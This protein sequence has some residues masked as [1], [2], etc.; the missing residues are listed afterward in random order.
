MRVRSA[1]LAK[2]KQPGRLTVNVGDT[3]TFLEAATN[4]MWSHVKMDDDGRLGVV[5]ASKLVEME[6][7][8][9]LENPT[10]SEQEDE[11]E[12]PTLEEVEA[13]IQ[14]IYEGEGVESTDSFTLMDLHLELLSKFEKSDV[15]EA[16]KS[17]CEKGITRGG[18][19]A[20]KFNS[21]IYSLVDI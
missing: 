5:S 10:D 3:C 14:S 4:P 13:A 1:Q 2:D 8:A 12:K 9:V 20:Y 11:K 16:L 7:E 6:E 19:A 18:E 15:E 17:L 21:T